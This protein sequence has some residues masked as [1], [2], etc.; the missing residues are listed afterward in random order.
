MVICNECKTQF[1]VYTQLRDHFRT[2]HWHQFRA[3]C[4]W[5]GPEVDKR[6]FLDDWWWYEL[7]FTRPHNGGKVKV[8][9][10]EDEKHAIYA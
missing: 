5:L 9:S 4:L 8:D 3:I 6:A 1:P 2:E 10:M 7:R